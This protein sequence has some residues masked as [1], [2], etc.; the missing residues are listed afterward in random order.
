MQDNNVL[1]SSK[2]ISNIDNIHG[3]RI[4]RRGKTERERGEKVN[5]IH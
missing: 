1:E 5:L 4:A 3:I 2:R